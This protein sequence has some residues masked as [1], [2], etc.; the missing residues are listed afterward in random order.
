LIQLSKAEELNRNN[1]EIYFIKGLNLKEMGDT[2]RAI[3]AFQKAVTVKSDFYD[4]YI[5]LGLLNSKKPSQLAAQYFDNA[6]RIDSSSEEAYYDKAKFFQDRGD[7]FFDK[8]QDASAN[9][10]YTKAKEVYHELIA[11]NPQYETAY[12]NLGFIYV[13]QDSLDKAYRM[14]DFTIKVKPAYAEAYYYRG[15]VS[16]DRGNSDQAAADFRQA[17]SL[18]PDFELAKKELELLTSKK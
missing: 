2:T 14:F 11:K 17:I 5:Q 1:A 4:A 9:E 13:R 8:N 16:E 7:V 10:N 18:R 12:F 6:I 15:L 3:A